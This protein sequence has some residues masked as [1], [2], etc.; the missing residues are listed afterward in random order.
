VTGDCAAAAVAY[1][2]KGVDVEVC[3][4]LVLALIQP[5]HLY[6]DRKVELPAGSAASSTL[7]EPCWLV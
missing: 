2:A 1:L 4:L 3:L 6:V 7:F 5:Y